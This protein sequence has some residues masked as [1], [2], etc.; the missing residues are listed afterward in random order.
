MFLQLSSLTAISG[1]LTKLLHLFMDDV[2]EDEAAVQ[3]LCMTV[4]SAVNA[5]YA[6]P[7]S[8]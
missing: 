4:S 1:S 6:L 2:V 7:L 3:L 8:P 5:H